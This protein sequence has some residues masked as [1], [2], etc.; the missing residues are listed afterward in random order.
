MA[1]ACSALGVA[2]ATFYDRARPSTGQ[3]QPRKNP[4][5][6]LTPPVRDVLYKPRFVDR[7]PAEVVTT[8]LDEGRYLCSERAMYRIL[9]AHGASRE[10]RNQLRH[11]AYT[12][13]ELMATV[14]NHFVE[15]H[16]FIEQCQ[17]PSPASA[18][19]LGGSLRSH[20]SP[21]KDPLLH[22]LRRSQ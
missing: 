16:T 1:P 4:A 8:L 7:S 21:P 5:R 17:C 14:P 12:K 22:Y 18:Q 13:P 20:R 6:A 15:Q 2:R 9:A 19:D 11:P 10:R 3:Q